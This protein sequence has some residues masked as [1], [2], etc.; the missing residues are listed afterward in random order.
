MASKGDP[1]PVGKHWLRGFFAW[2]PEVC[3]KKAKQID[4]VC[5][6]GATS[7]VIRSWFPRLYLPVIKSIKPVNCWNM[8]EAGIMEGMGVNGLVVGSTERRSI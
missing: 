6:N 2:H 5:T 8:D 4:S 7:G 3:T 1:L